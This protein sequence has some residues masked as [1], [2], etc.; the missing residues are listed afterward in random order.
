[1]AQLGK[2]DRAIQYL[3]Q[4]IERKPTDA[5]AHNNF[6]NVLFQSGHIAEAIVQYE[7][8]LKLQP[9]NPRAYANLAKTYAATNC[10]EPA[11]AAA[12]KGIELARLQGDK[13]LAYDIGNWLEGYHNYL[14]DPLK[15]SP[16]SHP[17]SGAK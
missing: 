7:Q 16:E 4:A 14:A 9:N 2:P 1:M 15:R 5:Q 6:G 11:I 8:T 12:E 13:H 10:S 17:T 3:Q